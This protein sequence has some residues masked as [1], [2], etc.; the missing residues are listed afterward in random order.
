MSHIPHVVAARKVRQRILELTFSDGAVKQVDFAAY[1]QRGGVFAALADPVFFDRFFVDL[2]TVCWPN[3]ADVAPERL[4]EIGVAQ[5]R[6]AE[7][8]GSAAPA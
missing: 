1:V 2:N 7:A 8:G 6:T 3:G 4:Y 5:G